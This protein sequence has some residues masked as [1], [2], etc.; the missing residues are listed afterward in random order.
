MRREFGLSYNLNCII[1]DQQLLE[2]EIPEEATQAQ[3]PRE[4]GK[5]LQEQ[6]NKKEG[7]GLQQQANKE[8]GEGKE[9][10]QGKRE[11]PKNKKRGWTCKLVN[12][13]I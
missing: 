5:G 9:N 3:Q 2:M 4:E 7:Q 6:A 8:E 10:A 13:C 11:E 12:M 1:Q